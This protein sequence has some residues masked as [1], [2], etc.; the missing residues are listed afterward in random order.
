M[1]NYDARPLSRKNLQEC[2]LNYYYYYYYYYYLYTHTYLHYFSNRWT[3]MIDTSDSFLHVSVHCKSLAS[4]MLLQGTKK[5]EIAVLHTPPL[6]S[7]LRQGDYG[8]LPPRETILYPVILIFLDPIS[9][10][11]SDLQQTPT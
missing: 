3:R 4:Q 1:W 6:V 10:L 8:P 11:T 9:C 5:P 2:N 7:T